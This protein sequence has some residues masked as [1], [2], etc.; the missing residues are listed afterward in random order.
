MIV[1]GF[2]YFSFS[3]FSDTHYFLRTKTIIC[4][5]GRNCCTNEHLLFFQFPEM[6][7]KEEPEQCADLTLRLLEK[8]SSNITS[9]RVQATA[10]LYLLMRHNFSMGNVSSS[11]YQFYKHFK[12]AQIVQY[13]QGMNFKF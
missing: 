10:S 5:S 2:M 4:G 8:C 11:M 9:I 6:L 1:C 12:A 7:F 13:C 3:Y